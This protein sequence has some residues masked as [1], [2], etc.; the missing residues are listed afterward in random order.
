[1]KARVQ[2]LGWKI[3]TVVALVLATSIVAVAQ[4]LPL[5]QNSPTPV[6]S[7]SPALQQNPLNETPP[8]IYGLQGVLIETLDNRIVAA[9]SVDQAFNPA[10]AVKLATAL[11]ECLNDG[12]G[13]N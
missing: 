5:P 7:P 3:S 1:M 10:S 9:Q 11:V 8:T 6:A 4:A 2:K 13:C 12:L